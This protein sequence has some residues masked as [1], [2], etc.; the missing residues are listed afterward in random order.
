MIATLAA[1]ATEESLPVKKA[2]RIV[3]RMEP[4]MVGDGAA[5]AAEV[6]VDVNLTGIAVRLEGEIIQALFGQKI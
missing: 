2:V 6:E 4:T 5:A 3:G 1:Q